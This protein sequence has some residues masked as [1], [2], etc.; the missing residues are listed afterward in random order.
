MTLQPITHV[1]FDLDGTLIDSAPAIL[2]AFD[3]AFARCGRQPVV[4]LAP[5][6]IG[7]PL[8][9]TLALL[10]GTRDTDVLQS[11]ADAFKEVYDTEG[12]KQTFVFPGIEDLLQ[13]LTAAGLTLY[14][15]TNKRLLPTQRILDYLGWTQHFAGVYALDAF[16]PALKSKA[17]M[18]G[19]VLRLHQLSHQHSIYV[20]DRD[21]DGQSAQA[22][23]LRFLLASWGYDGIVSA[24]WQR[25]GS[26]AALQETLITV[27]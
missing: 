1:L 16:S 22:N 4:T 12:Y 27:I 14:I 3:K 2:D 20:G 9:E 19:E 7:P 10:A 24:Q 6:I 11:L 8:M 26:P 18:I 23:G 5:A 13:S 21:E 17:D 15:A 25:V